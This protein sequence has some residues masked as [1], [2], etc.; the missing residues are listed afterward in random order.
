MAASHATWKA[1]ARF[2]S[3]EVR[4]FHH[5]S[6]VKTSSPGTASS[7]KVDAVCKFFWYSGVRNM[8]AHREQIPKVE[9]PDFPFNLGYLRCRHLEEPPTWCLSHIYWTLTRFFFPIG[10]HGVSLAHLRKNRTSRRQFFET[11]GRRF[12]LLTGP[13]LTPANSSDGTSRP[14]LF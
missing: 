2:W 4:W 12:H 3:D 9:P 14:L 5:P 13:W 1:S 8:P 6:R 10:R 11:I 7:G